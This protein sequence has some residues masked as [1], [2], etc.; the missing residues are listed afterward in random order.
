M[1]SDHFFRRGFSFL[2][3]LMVQ[4]EHERAT[5]VLLPVFLGQK[6]TVAADWTHDFMFNAELTGMQ[7]LPR[8]GKPFAACP[9]PVTS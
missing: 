8:S 2:S 9:S 6:M 7:Q 4:R 5:G 3:F 1:I